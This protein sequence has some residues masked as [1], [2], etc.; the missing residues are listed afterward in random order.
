LTLPRT[1]DAGQ[2]RPESHSAT[3]SAALADAVHS[4]W[5]TIS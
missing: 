5:Q 4:G 3:V 2:R 1:A